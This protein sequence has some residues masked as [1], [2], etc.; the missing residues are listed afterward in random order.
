[1]NPN[2]EWKDKGKYTEA[3]IDVPGYTGQLHIGNTTYIPKSPEE[4]AIILYGTENTA[5]RPK[6]QTATKKVYMD[7]GRLTVELIVKTKYDVLAYKTY[8]VLG[9]KVRVPYYKKKSETVTFTKSFDVPEIFPAFKPPKVYV[10]NYNGSHVIVYTPKLDGIVRVDSSYNSSKC[11]ERRLIGYIGTAENGFRST[12]FEKIDSWAFSGLQMSRSAHG[13]YIK[14]TDFNLDKLN[15]SV[16]T[17]YDSFEITE[18]EYKI[19]EDDSR[20][21]VNYALFAF[22]GCI[23]IYGRAIY[24]VIMMLVGRYF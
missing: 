22:I 13:V 9:Q 7:E 4:C 11:T 23:W 19:I 12:D 21:I 6:G 16:V 2:I 8:I 14:E 15:V 20:K 18:F 5:E 10:T 1:M 17:P 3:W 24:K